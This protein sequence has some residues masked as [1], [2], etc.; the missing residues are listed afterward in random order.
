MKSVSIAFQSHVFSF[1]SW[2]NT[3]VRFNRLS[4]SCIFI[5][6]MRKYWCTFQSPPSRVFS[7]LSRRN[8]EIYF[9]R[10][11]RV[12]SLLSWRH[13]HACLIGALPCIVTFALRKSWCLFQSAFPCIFTLEEIIMSVLMG[14]PVHFHSCHEEKIISVFKYAFPC[15]FTSDEIMM[16]VSNRWCLFLSVFSLLS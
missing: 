1:L 12:F 15:I 11:S 8:N 7:L 3:D 10:P 16:S 6:V 14:L 9:N 4:V 2:G 13:N 5:S